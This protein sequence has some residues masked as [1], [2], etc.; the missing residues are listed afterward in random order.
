MQHTMAKDA[1]GNPVGMISWDAPQ[2]ADT[3]KDK[4]TIKVYAPFNGVNG[5][6]VTVGSADTGGFFNTA[7]FFTD[8]QATA[9]AAGITIAAPV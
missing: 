5:M 9:T 3:A 2:W 7:Q 6:S 4:I 8:L 1:A